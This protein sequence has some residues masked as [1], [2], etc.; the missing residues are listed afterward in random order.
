MSTSC[1]LV[2]MGLPGAGKSTWVDA[3][4]KH[5]SDSC[6]VYPVCYDRLVPLDAQAEMAAAE[7]DEWKETRKEIVAAVRALL[8]N[9]QPESDKD[10]YYDKI[11]AGVVGNAEPSRKKLFIIDDNNY[12][13]SMRHAYY[14]AARDAEAGFCQL[15]LVLT[16]DEAKAANDRRAEAERLPAVVIDAMAE[17]LEAPKPM[18]NAWERFSFS[19]PAMQKEGGGRIEVSACLPMCAQV[20]EMAFANP[21]RVVEPTVSSE[22]RDASRAACTANVVHQ[23]DKMLRDCVGDSIKEFRYDRKLIP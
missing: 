19:V 4:A 20:I 2:M 6:A 17:K 23:A 10:S 14:K 15:H 11:C 9:E 8:V 13:A 18:A 5:F 3:L 21:A 7:T 1:V 22:E 12:Y 16:A